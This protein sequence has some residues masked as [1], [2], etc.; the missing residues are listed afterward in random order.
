VEADVPDQLGEDLR[1][2]FG[3]RVVQLLKSFPIT[4]SIAA[5]RPRPPTSP[6]M[7]IC[8]VSCFADS[9]PIEW[10]VFYLDTAELNRALGD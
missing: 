1:S 5:G 9:L 3:G 2:R 8:E 4:P 6:R 10:Q 7:S